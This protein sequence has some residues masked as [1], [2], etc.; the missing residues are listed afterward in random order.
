MFEIVLGSPS[1]ITLP[2]FRTN[3]MGY[4]SGLNQPFFAGLRSF[5][6]Q[7]QYA[8]QVILPRQVA[9]EPVNNQQQ[10]IVNGQDI[11]TRL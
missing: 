4:L 8:T 7:T 10:S 5:C 9:C 3:N 11:F 2:P 1:L 6:R